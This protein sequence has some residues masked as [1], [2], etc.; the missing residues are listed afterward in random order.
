MITE[1]VSLSENTRRLGYAQNTQIRL[2]G[3]TFDVI[4]DPVVVGE[5]LV[6]VDA[7]EQ[8]SG[9]RRR[10]RIPPAWIQRSR[11]RRAGGLH[12]P[13]TTVSVTALGA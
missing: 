11:S 8:K 6:F 7:L 13:E 5:N 1:D 12:G 4:S 3:E 10:V 2:Y 9:H